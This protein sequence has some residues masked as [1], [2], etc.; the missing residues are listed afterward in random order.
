MPC[1]PPSCYMSVLTSS[2]QTSNPISCPPPIPFSVFTCSSCKQGAPPCVAIWK[3]APT[4]SWY[5]MQTPLKDFLVEVTLNWDL[6][7]H[8]PGDEFR[9]GLCQAPKCHALGGH[10]PQSFHDDTKVTQSRLKFQSTMNHNH[11]RSLT[12]HTPN[13]HR[14]HH[15]HNDS[16]FDQH[17]GDYSKIYLV[18]GNIHREVSF[19]FIFKQLSAFAMC[20][21]HLLEGLGLC[22]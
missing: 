1:I 11:P 3:W 18:R 8:R 12:A 16:L 15:T 22:S 19:S 14:T 2:F 13:L 20:Y 10:S 21:L 5:H 7:L 9:E 17:R 4:D 6:A